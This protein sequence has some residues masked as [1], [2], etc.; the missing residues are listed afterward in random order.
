MSEDYRLWTLARGWDTMGQ[1]G[2]Q[3][4]ARIDFP[5]GIEQAAEQWGTSG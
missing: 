4:W 2:S 5:I 1:S 3:N